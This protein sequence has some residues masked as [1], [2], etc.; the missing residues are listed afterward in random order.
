MRGDWHYDTKL[1][2]NILYIVTWGLLRMLGEK[3]AE[4]IRTEMDQRGIRPIDVARLAE[5]DHAL[6]YNLLN[7]N[8]PNPSAVVTLKICLALSINPFS[9]IKEETEKEIPDELVVEVRRL[10][11]TGIKKDQLMLLVKF[12]ESLAQK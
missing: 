9:L 8:K 6:V 5:I 7:R 1:K 12:V 11:A 2:I 3:L 10:L 4:A